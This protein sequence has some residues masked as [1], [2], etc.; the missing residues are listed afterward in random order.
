MI[1]FTP[2]VSFPKDILIISFL[3]FW[4]VFV[5]FF[6]P[7]LAYLSLR[8][9]IS[10]PQYADIPWSFLVGPKHSPE[11]SVLS[12][13]CLMFEQFF[14]HGTGVNFLQHLD[15]YLTKKVAESRLNGGNKGIV[16][17]ARKLQIKTEKQRKATQ[18]DGDEAICQSKG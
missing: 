17:K 6:R 10:L 16:T 7:D 2:H 8:H 1:A 12:W 15:I 14:C 3:N 4:I 9:H 18:L 13:D 5:N 11:W